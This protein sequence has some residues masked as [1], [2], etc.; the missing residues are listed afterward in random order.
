MLKILMRMLGFYTREQQIE[1]YAK[2]IKFAYKQYKS[3]HKRKYI[4]I[5]DMEKIALDAATSIYRYGL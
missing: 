4:R 2:R 5:E 3:T 1:D